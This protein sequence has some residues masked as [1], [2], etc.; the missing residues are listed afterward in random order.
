MNFISYEFIVFFAAVT[1]LYFSLAH[2]AQNRMLLIAS[3]L[4]YG[5]WDWR[6]LGLLLI[7]SI[8]DF[9][10]GRIV[11]PQRDHP[12]PHT[13]RRLGLALSIGWCAGMLFGRWADDWDRRHKIGRWAE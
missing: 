5:W 8:V 2:R 13:R 6:F 1:A 11:D 10:V 9:L 3:Y 7:S 12:L 4:F